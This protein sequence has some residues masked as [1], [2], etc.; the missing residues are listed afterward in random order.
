MRKT[1]SD[2]RPE[3]VSEWSKK[4]YHLRRIVLHT[5]Q[6][7]WFGGKENADTSGKLL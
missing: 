1:L 6:I 4:T 2:V 3:L 5:A 7:N